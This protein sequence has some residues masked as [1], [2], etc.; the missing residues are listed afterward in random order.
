MQPAA[1]R[2]ADQIIRQ[3]E[4]QI[5]SGELADASPLPAEREL[6]ASFGASRTVVREA[7]TALAN[8]GLIEAKPRFR[9]I[10]RKPGVDEALGS[11]SHIVDHLL[12]APKGVRNLFDV[13]IFVERA[14]VRDAAL[15]ARRDDIDRL[16]DALACN[17]EAI[18]DSDRFYATDVAF[19]AVFYEIPKN[20][21]FPAIHRAFVSWLAAHWE[22]MLRSPERNRVN[23]KSHEA[24]FKAIT[25]RDPDAAEAALGSHLNAAWEYVRVTF[26]GVNDDGNL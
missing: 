15:R 20:P 13:R 23:Y 18:S 6:M 12:Q 10:V 1:P 3:L 2:A 22:L 16:E 7:I 21:I 8:R 26:D 19:H 11:I 14:L 5:L 17:H 25:L 9:P 24:I 4:Q